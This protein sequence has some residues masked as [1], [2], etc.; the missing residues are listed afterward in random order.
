MRLQCYTGRSSNCTILSVDLSRRNFILEDGEPGL[1]ENV[2]HAILRPP[3]RGG[4]VNLRS[5]ELVNVVKFEWK[6]DVVES[7][8]EEQSRRCQRAYRISKSSG[9]IDNTLRKNN[10]HLMI[11]EIDLFVKILFL[12]SRQTAVYSLKRF[13]WTK[14]YQPEI[15]TYSFFLKLRLCLQYK[16]RIK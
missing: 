12:R 3:A 9:F 11:V 13:Y 2:W 5:Y 15:N 6:L 10:Y 14:T 1:N 8:F 7:K 16:Y 4:L